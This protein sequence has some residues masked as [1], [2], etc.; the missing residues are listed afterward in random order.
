MGEQGGEGAG[1]DALDARGLAE[2]ARPHS[3]E[4]LPRL[5]GKTAD[6]GIVEIIR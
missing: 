2:G 4:F 1:R 3:G 6:A 5:I